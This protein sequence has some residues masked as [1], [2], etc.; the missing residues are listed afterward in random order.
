VTSVVDPQFVAHV[1]VPADGPDVDDA[2]G[3]LADIWQGCEL[4]FGMTDPVPGTGL[5]RALPTTRGALPV[6]GERALAVQQHPGTDCQAV[7]RLH[8]D[9]FN[10]SIGLTAGG[11]TG[12]VLGTAA[13]DPRWWQSVDYQWNLLA[14]RHARFMLG[15]ARL[16][17]APVAD[18]TAFAELSSMLPAGST[19]PRGPSA[20]A[21]TADGLALREASVEPDDR[22][23]R[24]L[25]LQMAPDADPVASAWVWSR[26]DATIPPLARYLLHAAKIRFEM[27]VWQR[28]S[29]ARQLQA[30][31]DNL[32]AELRQLDADH[33]A[34]ALLWQRRRD[35]L[36]LHTEL[37]TLRRTVEVAADNLGRSFDLSGLLAPGTL[38]ADDAELARFLL[39]R[40][41]DE[42]AYL[43]LAAER[44]GQLPEPH[45]SEQHRPER[46]RQRERVPDRDHRPAERL[47]RNVFVVYGRDDPVRRAV[48]D[49][50]RALDLRP[51]EWEALVQETGTTVPFL[52]EAVLKGLDLA[53]AVVVLMTPEDVVYL[54]PEL[55]ESGEQEAETSAALQARPNVLLELGMALAAKPAGTLV[56]L[57]GEHRPVSDLGGLN[58]IRIADTP[59][60]RRKIAARLRQAGCLVDD[61]GSDWLTAGDF[62]SLAAHDR[63]A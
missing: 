62:A 58:F 7:L 32:S 19:G 46:Q 29:Q 2:Y 35:A 49:F 4:L 15:E 41:D 27:R 37:R 14:S 21:V 11:T 34:R 30:T 45:K 56:L 5:P 24:R 57:I 26:G 48:F 63:S 60:C 53:P 9:V 3:A 6:G 20:V 23:L 25:V 1:F 36:L 10:L 43:G 51:L 31:L 17:L 13:A 28:D 8:H 55:H 47:K 39:E 54:H 50:L 59:H 44:A 18:G 61:S 42:I 40:L 38:F 12:T 16:Y 52:S 22:A 33:P